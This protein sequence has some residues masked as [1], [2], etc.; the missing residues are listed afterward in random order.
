M[1]RS[2][3]GSEWQLMTA[4]A[5]NDRA[6]S[7]RES[8]APS[9]SPISKPDKLN[10]HADLAHLV[11]RHLAKVEVAG[12]SP[13]IRSKNKCRMGY[14]LH[15][16]FIQVADL[17][18][19]WMYNSPVARYTFVYHQPFGLYIITRQRVSSCDLMIYSPESEIY[20]FSD[21]WYTT[22]RV[23]DIQGLRLDFG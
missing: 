3:S 1:A 21:G 18:Y 16:F 6:R 22:L 11:E 2:R 12:S 5:A 20:S 10:S 23:D 19:H 7:S 15:L 14:I 17:A 4:R 13:V 9:E 8:R